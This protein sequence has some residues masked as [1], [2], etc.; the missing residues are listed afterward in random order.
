M[1]MVNH[2][3][4]FA[5]TKGP[6][7][8][9]KPRGG[10]GGV[11][12]PLD[13]SPI[14]A[15]FT[16][17]HL[18]DRISWEGSSMKTLYVSM[19]ACGLLYSMGA[20]A[21]QPTFYSCEASGHYRIEKGGLQNR[22]SFSAPQHFRV[23]IHTG[24]MSGEGAF[25]SRH[26]ARTIVLDNGMSPRGSN[27]KVVYSSPPGDEYVNLAYLQIQAEGGLNKTFIFLDSFDVFT[28]T[29]QRVT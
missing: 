14:T 13:P 26:W 19:L 8:G 12:G 11:Q 4:V 27:Y 10:D 15:F 17:R 24:A 22:S 20:L 16:G 29:C 9:S 28:G 2:L 5:V 6:G 7:F 25:T 1:G 3:S 18:R 23:N 21:K